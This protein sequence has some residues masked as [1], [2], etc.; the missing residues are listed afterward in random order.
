MRLLTIAGSLRAASTNA[1]ALEALALVAPDG[2]QV[3]RYRELARLPAFNPD[4][5]ETAERRPR[6]QRCAPV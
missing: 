2:I 4:D 3:V 6:L 5:D 1:A